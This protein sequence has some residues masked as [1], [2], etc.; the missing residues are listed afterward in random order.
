MFFFEEESGG[1]GESAIGA[2]FVVSSTGSHVW[3][4]TFI[5]QSSIPGTWPIFHYDANG[6]A[7]FTDPEITGGYGAKLITST[8]TYYTVPTGYFSVAGG[9]ANLNAFIN[10]FFA[11]VGESVS[12]DTAT[13][14]L[15]SKT[16]TLVPA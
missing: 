9:E 4:H 3:Q 5:I 10:V 6:N 2:I 15:V 12:G 11:A 8:G 1:G 16:T 13:L 7:V 14:T